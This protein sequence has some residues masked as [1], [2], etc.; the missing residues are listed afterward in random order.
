ME[1]RGRIDILINNAGMTQNGLFVRT[2]P[3]TWDSVMG[4]NLTGAF[5][6][7]QA[8]IRYMIK[9]RWGRIINMT[10]VVALSGNAG[11]AAYSASK[12]GIVGLTRS[13]A[14]EL[15]S[16]NICVNAVAPGLIAT[17]MTGTM[18]EK[19]KGAV[20]DQVPLG[21]AGTPDDVAGV[22]GFLA[23]AKADYITGQVIQVNGG[24]YM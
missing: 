6:C 7:C 19:H 10:S 5:N 24:L 11:Q 1:H 12:A 14:R 21:R 16:R 17:D 13:L 4:V 8:V 15:G 3:E 9:Q 23:S 18:E 20:L 22:V 2:K